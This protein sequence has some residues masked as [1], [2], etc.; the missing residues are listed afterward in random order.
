MSCPSCGDRRAALVVR[1]IRSHTLE[2]LGHSQRSKRLQW[3]G[4]VPTALGPHVFDS[5]QNRMACL[6]GNNVQTGARS[7]V[8][9]IMAGPFFTQNLTTES[10]LVLVATVTVGIFCIGTVLGD[11]EPMGCGTQ[12]NDGPGT[13]QIVDEMLHLTIR[14]ILEAGE[15]HHQVGLGKFL[16][17]RHVTGSRLNF[18]LCINPEDDRTL[19]AM[20]LGENRA[21][22]GRVSSDLYS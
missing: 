12:T 7:M 4:V 2:W 5:P 10:V 15:N 14:P 8:A 20:T 22:A 13:V 9:T 17:S 16:D 6:F 19:E 18:A 21:R 3:V 1:R 11:F